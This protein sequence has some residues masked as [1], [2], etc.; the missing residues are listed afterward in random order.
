MKVF[1]SLFGPEVGQLSAKEEERRGVGYLPD[2]KLYGQRR[3]YVGAQYDAQGMIKADKAGADK[4]HGKK[5][6]RRAAL[7]YYGGKEARKESIEG[8]PYREAY[9]S[10]DAGAKYALHLRAQFQHA[11]EKEGCARKKEEYAM[12]HISYQL[13]AHRIQKNIREA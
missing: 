11:Q 8:L 4:P 13:T 5:R 12:H 6:C 9:I 7:K 2:D 10:A 1:P 3:A